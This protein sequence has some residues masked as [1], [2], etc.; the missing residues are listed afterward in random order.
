MSK[1]VDLFLQPARVFEAERERPTFLVPLAIV[2]LLTAA[3]TLAY[4]MRVDPAWYNEHVLASLGRELSATEAAQVKASMPGPRTQGVIAAVMGA[5]AVVVASVLVA[6]Y[7]WLA[8]KVTGRALGFRHGMSLSTWSGLPM[9]LG[10]LVA[11]AGALTMAPQTALESL[12]LT[13][14][15]PLLVDLPADHRWNRLAQGFNL[16]TLWTLWLFALGWKTWTRSS[17][18]QAIVVALLPT[19]LV[20]GVIALIP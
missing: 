2:V 4:F 9:A 10:L 6:L 7:V 5:V 14:V 11:L 15:D 13:N 8:A 16:L 3:F 20:F 12:M 1:L 19:L 18:G 17:W